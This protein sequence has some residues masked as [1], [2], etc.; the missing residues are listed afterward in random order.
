MAKFIMFLIGS[1]G[2]GL[3]EILW[4]GRTHFS[5]LL[6]GGI[7]FCSFA[8]LADKCKKLNI[9]IKAIIGS[10]FVTFIELVFGVF[11]NLILKQNIW[12]YSARPFNFK[13]QICLLYSIYWAILSLVFIPFAEKVNKRLQNK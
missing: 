5:M 7:C 2:Y 12:N 10:A 8:Y 4:R 11:F 3:I 6:A 9:F 1:F 13:G